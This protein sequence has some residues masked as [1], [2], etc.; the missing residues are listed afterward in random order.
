MSSTSALLAMSFFVT[1]VFIRSAGRFIYSGQKASDI[2]FDVDFAL[3][4]IPKDL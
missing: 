4:R 1:S 3:L 2:E